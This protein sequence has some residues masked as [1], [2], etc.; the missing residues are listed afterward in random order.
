MKLNLKVKLIFTA[1]LVAITL[2]AW[3]MTDDQVISYI[4]AQSAAGKTNQQIGK[5]LMAQGVPAAQIQRIRAKY[6]R[7]GSVATGTMVEAKSAAITDNGRDVPEETTYQENELVVD[8]FTP[9]ERQTARE[10][11]GHD[12]FNSRGLTFDPNKNMATPRDYRLGP[13]DE[14]VID[15]WGAAEEHIRETISPEG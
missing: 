11:Y 5:E 9:D 15:V 7:E 2:T 12:L 3:A 4:R 8:V 13:G 14:V 6:Q 10:V 1:V